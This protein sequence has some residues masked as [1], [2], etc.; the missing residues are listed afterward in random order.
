MILLRAC[1]YTLFIRKAH[2]ATQVCNDLFINKTGILRAW[3]KNL[4]DNEKESKHFILHRQNVVHGIIAAIV[5]K[6]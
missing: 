2:L 4:Q 1:L 3:I 5:T 6:L